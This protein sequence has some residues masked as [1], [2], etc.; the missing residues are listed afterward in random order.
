MLETKRAIFPKF[1]NR[2]SRGQIPYYQAR[3]YAILG[4]KDLAVD[5][6]KKS[7]LEGNIAEHDK[8]VFEWD[9][10]NLKGYPPFEKLLKFD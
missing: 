5:Y 2:K 7:K 6:L 3:I 1:A 8:F 10:T 4:E 9:L